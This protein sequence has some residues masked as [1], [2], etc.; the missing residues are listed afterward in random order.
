MI[1]LQNNEIHTSAMTRNGCPGGRGFNDA[2]H[3]FVQA[4]VSPVSI[5]WTP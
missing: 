5:F 1:I 4:G 2:L 3:L